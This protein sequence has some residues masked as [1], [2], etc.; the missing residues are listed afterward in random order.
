MATGVDVTL[1]VDI[2]AAVV[3]VVCYCDS[4]SHCCCSGAA[5]NGKELDN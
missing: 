4:G 5:L 2:M 3:A 1:E